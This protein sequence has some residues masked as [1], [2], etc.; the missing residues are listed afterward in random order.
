MKLH[1][2]KEIAL[3][4]LNPSFARRVIHGTNMTVANVIL[5]KG[6]EVPWH[7]HLNEQMTVM[8]TGKLLFEFEGGHEFIVSEGQVME[9]IPHLPHR[10]VA[11]EDSSAF[12]LFAPVRE[13]WLKGNDAYLRGGK[14]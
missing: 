4:Q 11:L 8:L 12:D 6:S 7:S 10:V 14:S 1:N 2:W 5:T 9:I 13:D 3:E